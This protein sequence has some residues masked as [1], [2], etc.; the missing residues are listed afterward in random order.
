MTD[1]PTTQSDKPLSRPAT[2]E[3]SAAIAM[4][5][6][7]GGS[8]VG[9]SLRQARMSRDLSIAQVAAQLRIRAGHIHDIEAG[10]FADLPGVAYAV[11]FVRAYAD[12][13]GLDGEELAKAF[14]DEF[15]AVA[16]EPELRMPLAQTER[17]IPGGAVLFASLLC[18]VGAYAAWYLTAS[19]SAGPNV[20]AGA[21]QASAV[22]AEAQP[23]PA[24]AGQ[25]KTASSAEPAANAAA[26]PRA[27]AAAGAEIAAAE[28]ETGEAGAPVDEMESFTLP[29][30]EPAGDAPAEEAQ[31]AVAPAASEPAA[32]VPAEPEPVAALQTPP[33]G[34]EPIPDAPIPEPVVLDRVP[35]EPQQE[36][37][38]GSVADQPPAEQTPPATP[39]AAEPSAQEAPDQTAEVVAEPASE[40]AA[41]EQP[42]AAPEAPAVPEIA[43]SETAA[44]SAPDSSQ[45][46]SAEPSPGGT[47]EPQPGVPAETAQTAPEP[48]ATVAAVEPPQEPAQ[49]AATAEEAAPTQPPAAESWQAR[50]TSPMEA[51]AGAIGGP[52]TGTAR[53]VIEVTEDCWVQVSDGSDGLLLSRVLRAGESFAVPDAKGLI[54]DTGNAGALVLRIDGVEV[55]DL[56][57]MGEVMRGVPLDPEQLA[58]A[59]QQ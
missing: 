42:Q 28:T 10:H 57:K 16:S 21:E 40:G 43:Q 20:I 6:A 45:T 5:Y 11:G 56:G 18:A 53:I 54:M 7:R 2:W 24:S 27:D 34:F 14:R 15:A 29:E 48:A 1:Q 17:S 50:M 9:R 3:E 47:G 59:A 37:Q 4:N 49:P 22:V 52:A 32:S 23:V 41:G 31:T 19:E 36:V 44:E 33:E 12:F 38:V 13:V 51:Q 46:A 30:L 26:E 39:A 58:S 25:D 8:E 55:T 35:S